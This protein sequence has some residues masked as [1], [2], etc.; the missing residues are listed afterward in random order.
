VCPGALFFVRLSAKSG[1]RIQLDTAALMS[2]RRERAPAIIGLRIS[3]GKSAASAAQARSMHREFVVDLPQR[4]RS[5][6]L[7]KDGA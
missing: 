6:R 3:A 5:E 1:A 2:A 4:E 7:A